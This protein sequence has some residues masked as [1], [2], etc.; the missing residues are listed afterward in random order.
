MYKTISPGALGLRVN[1]L[2]EAVD[3]AKSSGFEGV[4]FNPAEVADLID[5]RGA[6]H[7]RNLFSSSG[8]RPAGFGLPTDWRGDEAK[9][10]QGMEELPRLAKAAHAIDC[11]RTMTWIMPCSNDRDFDDNRRFHIERFRPIAS[12]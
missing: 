11:H 12:I 6:E 8:V 9:W 1:N 5:A 10:L 3:L 7:V 2:Q 4:E